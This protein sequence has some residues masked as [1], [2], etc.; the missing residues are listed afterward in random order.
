MD[1]NFLL[2]TPEIRNLKNVNRFCGLYFL[3]Y[4][5]DVVYVGCSIDVLSRVCNHKSDKVFDYP[6]FLPC[7]K[8]KML[9]LEKMYIETLRPKYNII[10]NPERRQK[11]KFER[12][13]AINK[14]DQIKSWMEDGRKMWNDFNNVVK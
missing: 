9:E 6:V 10:H 5:G 13:A 14:F 4:R 7:A 12:V 3:I 2:S 11:R 1:V 8:S